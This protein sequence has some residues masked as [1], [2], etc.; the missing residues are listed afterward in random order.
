VGVEELAREEWRYTG[1]T[2]L[3]PQR[4]M[5]RARQG[6]PSCC[7]VIWAKGAIGS[8]GFLDHNFPTSLV[9][10]DPISPIKG[11]IPIAGSSALQ[12]S[13][14]VVW[15]IFTQFFIPFLTSKRSFTTF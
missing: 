9:S 3:G 10:W 4:C 12:H 7:K 15:S 13:S 8:I 5:P 14:L 1:Y 6:W 2:C 11:L